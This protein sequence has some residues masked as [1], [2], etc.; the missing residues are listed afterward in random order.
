MLSLA[1]ALTLLS[2]EAPRA[3]TQVPAWGESIAERV[4]TAAQAF[5]QRSGPPSYAA[6]AR[7]VTN[8]RHEAAF[9]LDPAPLS[10][11]AA[12][13]QLDRPIVARCVK[14]NN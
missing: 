8:W 12:L 5:Q 10:A 9:A 4:T 13:F 14:L 7:A 11:L 6:E 3:L 2:G 1:L